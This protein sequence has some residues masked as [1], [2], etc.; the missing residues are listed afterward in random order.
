M[1]WVL[2]GARHRLGA[3]KGSVCLSVSLWSKLFL[4]LSLPA[5]IGLFLNLKDFLKEMAVGAGRGVSSDT[6]PYPPSLLPQPW[7]NSVNLSHRGQ[8]PYRL[9]VGTV[10][11]TGGCCQS[12]AQWVCVCPS[13][14]KAQLLHSA[15][16][17]PHPPLGPKP[18]TLFPAFALEVSS[19][20]SAFMH[21]NPPQPRKHQ[22]QEISGVKK[23]VYLSV[24]TP[25]SMWG[26]LV[27]Q[28][29]IKS[30]PPCSGSQES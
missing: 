17:H 30:T 2:V 24:N 15:K 18:S 26:I 20:P 4:F 16:A 11:G 10:R 5:W 14:N 19:F 23:E 25:Q 1:R 13:Q 22:R 6:T 9:Q 12:G 28:P 21:S 7:T 3:G 8:G 27:P 29:G